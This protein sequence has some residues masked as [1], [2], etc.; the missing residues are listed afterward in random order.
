MAITFVSSGEQFTSTDA[1]PISFT[2]D[3]GTR[4]DGLLLVF[5]GTSDG[6]T[7]THANPTWNG[8]AMGEAETAISLTTTGVY[9][10]VS[11]F[12]LV[13]PAN[14]SNAFSLTYADGSTNTASFSYVVAAWFDGAFQTQ[15]SILDQHTNATGATDPSLS[16]TPAEDNE[17]VVAMYASEAD[18]VLTPAQGATIQDADNGTRTMGVTYIIQTTAAAQTM[19][20]TGTDNNWVGIIA[21]FKAVS[22]AQPP[23]VVLNTADAITL[24]QTPTL[25]FTGTSDAADPIRYNIQVSTS[26]I[27]EGDPYLSDSVAGSGASIHPNPNGETAW[28][29]KRQVDD[30]PGQSLAG[31]GGFL[32]QVKTQISVD[33]LTDGNTVARI[34]EHAG[35]FG[36]TSAPLNA[37]AVNDT[38]TPGWI[39]QSDPIYFDTGSP[40]QVYTFDFDSSNKP[41]L[42][43]G[44]HYMLLFDWWAESTDFTNTIVF[45]GDST[46]TAAGNAYIDGDSANN[47]PRLDFD[48]T[49]ELYE[50]AHQLD[51][52]SGTDSG[53]SG[54]PDNT[55][56]FA[57][58]QAVTFTVQE[59]DAL[60]VGLTY[61]WRVRGIDPDGTNTYGDWSETREFTVGGTNTPQTVAGT[62]T[63][64]GA[65]IKATAKAPTGT[66]T[67]AGAIVKSVAKSIPGTLTSSGALAT[68]RGYVRAFE[69]TL[70]SSGALIR[71]TGK[72]LVGT[73]TSSGA[74]VTARG[75]AATL[76]GT[77][78]SSGA[79]NR[80]TSK[81]LSGALT[82]AGVLQR[83]TAKLFVGALATAGDLAA[84]LAGG[85]AQA[86]GGTLTMAGTITRATAK[87]LAGTLTPA[88]AISRAIGKAI[89]GALSFLGS[90]IA[91]LVGEAEAHLDVTLTDAA[92]YVVTL[93]DSAVTTATLTDSAVYTVAL[94]DSSRS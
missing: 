35:T 34:Y 24:G 13:N 27:F 52:V 1:T 38:P 37:A 85:L 87:N 83:N 3:I 57:S 80:A 4:T 67:T 90:L 15:A 30:R 74:L 43:N 6:V 10:R 5:V 92:V 28:T 50:Q 22:V 89:S 59:A 9:Q 39:A 31:G 88:G 82:S 58:A 2:V 44:T 18:A 23:I 7:H 66:L 73:V 19:S 16:G 63:T 69:G 75:Y 45:T 14:G 84:E 93:T 29:G 36:T 61:Y 46:P 51:K 11:C 79:L 78:T 42:V 25:S 81:L 48:I 21:T 56:P 33:A 68:A 72:A 70:T 55:D 86:V 77:L 64:A 41:L 20:W 53:Y 54:T 71:N 91:A 40:T 17:L 76:A 60:T 47:G 32:N 94:S 49:F 65:I 12:Y 8:V 26:S 62:L